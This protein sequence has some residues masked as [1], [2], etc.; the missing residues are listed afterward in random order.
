MYVNQARP[1]IDQSLI[2]HAME[3]ALNGILL[4]RQWTVV[5]LIRINYHSYIIIFFTEV[6]IRKWESKF[7]IKL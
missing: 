3:K 1:L 5:V 2:K 7:N 4:N 6:N